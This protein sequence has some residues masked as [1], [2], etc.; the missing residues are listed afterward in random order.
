MG[1]S[2]GCSAQIFLMAE[3]KNYISIDGKLKFFIGVTLTLSYC[4]VL[5]N[6]HG[7][8]IGNWVYWTLI[9]HSYR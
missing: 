2:L 1:Q 9:T 8:S 5:V 3:M 7:V 6:R 4:H